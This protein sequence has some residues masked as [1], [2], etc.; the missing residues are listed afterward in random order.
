MEA[1][2]I[3]AAAIFYGCTIS[4]PKPARHD[5]ILKSIHCTM[6]LCALEAGKQQGFL[7]STG[8]YVNR[9]EAYHIAWRAKQIT[10]NT[11]TYPELYSEDLW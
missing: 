2:S 7:T 9:V 11:P 10:E 3:V 6:G 4:L 1:E 8:R 5:T